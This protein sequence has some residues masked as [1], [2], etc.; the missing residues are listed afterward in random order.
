M[1]E[2]AVRTCS[3]RRLEQVE[4]S[5]RIGIEVIKGYCRCPVMR[6]L[7]RRVHDRI[8]LYSLDQSQDAESIPDVELMVLE[9]HDIGLQPPLIPPSTALRSEKNLPLIVVQ[10]MDRPAE[11]RK[12]GTN[13]GADQAG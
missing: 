2:R 10:P 12:V 11:S 1:D 9:L 3:P 8:G 7:R 4:R 5:H 13:F 6:R